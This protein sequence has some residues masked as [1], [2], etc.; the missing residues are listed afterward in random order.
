MVSEA[1][2]MAAVVFVVIATVA[3]FV[4]PPLFHVERYGA[5]WSTACHNQHACVLQRPAPH[6]E[7]Q[8]KRIEGKGIDVITRIHSLVAVVWIVSAL[9]ALVLTVLTMVSAPSDVD[10]AWARI[11]LFARI[12]GYSSVV[13][14]AVGLAYSVATTWRFFRHRKVVVNWV[15]FILATALGGPSIVAIK[16]HSAIGV[17][18]LTGAELIVLAAASMIGVALR[19]E[20]RAEA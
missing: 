16:A 20:R 3:G 5:Q 19:R 17:I 4:L 11:T 14:F 12:A 6:K 10:A 7:T 9:V 13:M 15:L 2:R 1:L 18:G 8:M